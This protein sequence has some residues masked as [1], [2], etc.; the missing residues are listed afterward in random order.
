MAVA[1]AR[2][3]AISPLETSPGNTTGFSSFHILLYGKGDDFRQ[4]VENRRNIDRSRL[5]LDA[6]FCTKPSVSVR[7]FRRLLR[8]AAGLEDYAR[9]S[10]HYPRRHI[11]PELAREDLKLVC[12]ATCMAIR[13]F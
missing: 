6:I 1:V 9:T 12:F 8:F 3:T 7:S 5:S 10:G 4:C 13:R 11:F 2:Q